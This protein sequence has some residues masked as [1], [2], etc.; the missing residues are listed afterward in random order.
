ML[1][2]NGV[3]H[4]GVVFAIADAAA[5]GA[6]GAKGE[7]TLG[8]ETSTSFLSSV[9]AGETVVASAESVHD[10]SKTTHTYVVVTTADDEKVATLTGRGYKL[11]SN[12]RP[13]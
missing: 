8:L 7:V 3:L 1:N 10:T 9:E 2:F 6:E 5:G 4:G 13:V 11:S 12:E